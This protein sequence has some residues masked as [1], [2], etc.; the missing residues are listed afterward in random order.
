MEPRVGVPGRLAQGLELGAGSF[1]VGLD[2]STVSQIVGDG[3]I[4]FTPR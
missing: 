4:G 2:L 1:E 3:S